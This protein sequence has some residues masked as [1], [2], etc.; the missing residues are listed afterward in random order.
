PE[1]AAPAKETLRRRRTSS[2]PKATESPRRTLAGVVFLTLFLLAIAAG[3]G[4][5]VFREMS[6]RGKAAPPTAQAGGSSLSES[7]YIR[8]GWQKEAYA[9]L[10]KF[11][12]AKT[13]GE[14]IPYI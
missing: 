9:V 2:A 14:K 1:A 8:I 5:M 12:A 10:E 11:L 7:Q 4:Y 6:G 3:A 13:A